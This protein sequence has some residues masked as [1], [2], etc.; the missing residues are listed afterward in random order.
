MNVIRQ[1]LSYYPEIYLIILGII[2]M[3]LNQYLIGTIFNCI[4]ILTVLIRVVFGIKNLFK[5]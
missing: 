1:F 3:M 2:L 4:A 5:K